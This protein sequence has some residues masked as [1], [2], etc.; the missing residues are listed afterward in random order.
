[1]KKFIVFLILIISIMFL[2]GKY[3]EPNKFKIKEYNIVDSNIPDSFNGYKII[4]ITDLYY[5]N[6][7]L[8][9]I[10]DKINNIE[11]DLVVFTGNLL[12]N[13]F[14]PNQKETLINYLKEI[15]SKYGIYSVKGD[16]DNNDTYTE[17]INNSNITL[18]ENNYKYL[19]NNNYTP[20]M[21][22]GLDNN[23]NIDNTFNY[24]DNNYYKIVLSHYPDNYD[25]IEN[26][27]INLFLSGNSLN[28]QIRL[29]LLGGIIKKEGSK[30]YYDEKYYINNTTIY[31]SNGIGN[32]KYDFRLFNTPSIN[33]YRLY[34]K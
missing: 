31:I 29:P 28:G 11:P 27:E 32:P 17:I 18:L 13:E 1:M 24:E 15:K 9:L 3:I 19:Y 2:Y 26:K 16:N 20:I 30:K 6:K 5:L 21:L 4:H 23:L 25:L 34:S 12:H 8:S 33:L 22:I 10:I 7:D 14:D